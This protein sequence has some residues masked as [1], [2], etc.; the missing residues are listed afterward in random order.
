M[1]EVCLDLWEREPQDAALAAQARKACQGLHAYAAIFP[2]G[3]PRALLHEVRYAWLRGRHAAARRA[4]QQS[5]R[6]SE[7]LEMPFEKALAQYE[8]GRHLEP[9]DPERPVLLSRA[10]EAFERLGTR[11]YAERLS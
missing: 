8:I 5:Q 11:H 9:G 7:T 3:K 1:A 6:L 2:I 4:W 10:R